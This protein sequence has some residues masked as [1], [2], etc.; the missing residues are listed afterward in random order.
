MERQETPAYSL[1]LDYGTVP[2][3]LL[4][5]SASCSCFGHSVTWIWHLKLW[6]DHSCKSQ[7]VFSVLQIHFR[8]C[9]AAANRNNIRNHW[10][11]DVDLLE[12]DSQESGQ[13]FDQ[14]TISFRWQ[15]PD[16]GKEAL[17]SS[18]PE[19]SNKKFGLS[20]FAS[21]TARMSWHHLLDNFATL[22]LL[23]YKVTV[24]HIMSPWEL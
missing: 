21:S 23:S 16:L 6:R 20:S 22:L 18:G 4:W 11:H 17:L 5:A 7:A 3:A 19:L 12:V 1:L 2:P 15:P 13:E 10:C 24:S 9:Y 14:A 8:S